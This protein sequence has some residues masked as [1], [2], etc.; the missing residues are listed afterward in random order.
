M[1]FRRGP[2]RRVL[3]LR[4]DLSTDTL[5]PGQWLAGTIDEN[6]CG[7]SP[8][9]R[10]LVYF[11]K[12]FATKMR[13]FTAI[14]RPPWFTALALWPDGDTWGGGGFF[15]SNQGLVLGYGRIDH[16][17]SGGANIPHGFSIVPMTEY[18]AL[19]ETVGAEASRGWSYESMGG[20][21]GPWRRWKVSPADRGVR[22]DCLGHGQ[23]ELVWSRASSGVDKLREKL[24]DTHWADWDHDGSLLSSH[25]G[26]LFRRRRQDLRRPASLV[27]DLTDR[28]PSN[29]K[30]PREALAWPGS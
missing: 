9:G 17:L 15:V 16:E 24:V 25:G 14:S 26:R 28:T 7:L 8:D 6:K 12:K 27:A 4:W 21:S 13:T 19:V 30:P 11:A 5:I 3:M 1:L 10:L 18:R 29:V 20:E 2:A 22:L 23:Y